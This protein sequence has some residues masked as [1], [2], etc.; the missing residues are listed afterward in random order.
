MYI[1]NRIHHDN[2]ENPKL[3]FISK[4]HYTLFP[5]GGKHSTQTDAFFPLPAE[6]KSFIFLNSTTI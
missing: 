6:Q 1:Q 3:Q 4:T 2:L 5:H